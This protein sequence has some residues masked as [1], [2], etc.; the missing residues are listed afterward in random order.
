MWIAA[1][2]VAKGLGVLATIFLMG[3]VVGIVLTS[4]VAVQLRRRR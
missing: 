3:V 4:M 1:G 2:I